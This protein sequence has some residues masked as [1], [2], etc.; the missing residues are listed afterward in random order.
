MQ[1]SLT[2]LH[3]TTLSPYWKWQARRSR[4]GTQ[5]QGSGYR[6]VVY[7]TSKWE[8]GE[9]SRCT[10]CRRLNETLD[11]LNQCHNE[12]RMTVFV[13]QITLIE[14]WMERTYP[15]HNLQYWLITYL[16]KQNK[17][18][19]QDLEGLPESMT[20]IVGEHGRIG[21]ANFAEERITLET[22]KQCTCAI[23]G[24]RTHKT[25]GWETSSRI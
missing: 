2:W 25:T 24:Q 16:R 11:Y 3:G 4:R 9:D 19:F 10:S 15:H 20:S 13:D 7:W 17:K 23:G 6:G 21:W 5:K 8:K 18:R 14:E 22:C 1:R 12:T